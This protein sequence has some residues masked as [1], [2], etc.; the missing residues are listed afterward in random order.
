MKLFITG[1][2]GQLGNCLRDRI[3]VD[4]RF[5]AV[6]SDLDQ[7]DITDDEAVRKALKAAGCDLMVNCAAYTAVDKAEQEPD[8]A[9][10]I[11]G[12]GVAVLASACKDAGIPMIHISTDYI[13]SGTGTVPYTETDPASPKTSYGKSKRKGEEAF[14][15]SG[16]G[17]FIIRTSWLYSEYGHNFLKTMLRLGRQKTELRVVND[18]IGCPTYAGDLADAILELAHRLPATRQTDIIHYSNA[19]QT[20]WFGFASAIM[21]EAD[22]D[23]RVI[24]VT[25]AEYPTLAKRPVYSVLSV[26]KA[27]EY[28]HLQIPEWQWSLRKCISFLN[29]PDE[30]ERT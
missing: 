14:L 19:G 18:Q 30:K 3:E 27:K 5:S 16:V 7:L 4:Q 1:A 13:F 28:Y 6:Y 17:G 23:C 15:Q 26:A 10:H 12:N 21:R 20:T 2:Y 25:S 11:N 22:I 29:E 24:P 9:V 8:L